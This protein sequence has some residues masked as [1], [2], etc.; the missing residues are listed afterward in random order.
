[1]TTAKPK[2]FSVIIREDDGCWVAKC[3]DN[4]VTSQGKTI[5]AAL[6]NLK[7]TLELYYDDEATIAIEDFSVETV[8]GVKYHP[9]V[10][11]Q[12]VRDMYRD[13]L[14]PRQPRPG[15]VKKYFYDEMR[16][17]GFDVHAWLMRI[18]VLGHIY[19]LMW[20]AVFLFTG[21]QIVVL[22]FLEG[23]FFLAL[24]CSFALVILFWIVFVAYKYGDSPE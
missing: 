13:V 3:T 24:G 6:G 19:A 2:R 16:P 17:Y 14:Q 15:Y 1:M 21:W 9:G 8:G 23:R 11:Q 18:P 7:E 12:S 20:L 4:S 10:T 22:L 5:E